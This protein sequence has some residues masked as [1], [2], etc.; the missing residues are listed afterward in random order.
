MFVASFIGS[1]PMNL[2]PFEGVLRRGDRAIRLRNAD[3]TV[4][5]VL[6]DG[7]AGSFVLGI[8]PEHVVLSDT[9]PLRGCIFGAEYLGTTQIVTIEIERGRI[10][11][12][13]PARV[14]VRP[15]ETVGVDFHPERLAVFDAA[16]GRAWRSA[17]YEEHGHG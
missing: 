7:P 14:P 2:V 10:K 11:A 5:E 16:T 4:P 17:L 8:R 15:G 12:R 9:A 1:P 3:I 13:L 6:E